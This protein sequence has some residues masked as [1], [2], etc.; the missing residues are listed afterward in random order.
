MSLKWE[1]NK[2]MLEKIIHR[3]R[4][5]D[6]L[7]NLIL[8][9][10]WGKERTDNMVRLVSRYINEKDKILDIGCGVC[11]VAKN[12][13]DSGFDVA[14]LDVKDISI[15]KDITPVVYDGEKIPFEN[16]F[17]DVAFL[18][19]VLHH[20]KEPEKLLREAKRVSKRI[21]IIEDIYESNFQK[22]LTYL[23]DSLINFEFIGHPHSNK[24]D[25]EWKKE[26]KKQ[27]LKL[28]DFKKEPFWKYFLSGI[29]YLAK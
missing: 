26:F 15:H 21:I 20:I 4:E 29:Y 1:F 6:F 10:P 18:I 28:L 12:L 25:K 13:V 17:F 11:D 27:G 19:T 8:S 2:K 9:A 7:V 22:L 23:M 16:D 24:S 14:A 5:S 3:I